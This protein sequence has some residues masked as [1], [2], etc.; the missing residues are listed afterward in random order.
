MIFTT[1]ILVLIVT[2]LVSVVFSMGFK[3]KGPWDSIFLFFIILFL[4]VW[5]ASVWIKPIGPSIMGVYWAPIL[6]ATLI[7]TIFLA[8]ATP[9]R[10]DGNNQPPSPE[11]Q[12]NIKRGKRIINIF[13]WVLVVMLA[14][15]IFLGYSL[16][17]V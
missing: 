13:F 15:L 9:R 8:A 7:M 17:T 10:R 2:I 6:F 11:G 3:S 1:F 16:Q 14:V 4:G 5:A 12:K